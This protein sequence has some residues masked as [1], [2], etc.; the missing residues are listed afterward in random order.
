MKY[1]QSYLLLSDK[2]FGFLGERSTVFQLL[3]VVDKWTEILDQGGAIDVIYCDFQ[4][5]FD[6]VSHGR[7]LD[8]LAH[9]GIN[10]PNTILN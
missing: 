7:L 10:D 3:I 2:Q 6:T 9:Y 1:L 4:K 8:L 5:A